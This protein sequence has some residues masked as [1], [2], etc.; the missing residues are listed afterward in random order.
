MNERDVHSLRE[1][2]KQWDFSCKN[3]NNVCLTLSKVRLGKDFFYYQL[4]LWVNDNEVRN[5]LIIR[6]SIANECYLLMRE[7]LNATLS[8]L[9]A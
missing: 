2:I 8:A 7:T 3:S 5:N 6:E 1:P 4:T 9:S